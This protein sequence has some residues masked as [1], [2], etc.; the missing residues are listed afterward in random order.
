MH[1]TSLR[2]RRST[3]SV[4]QDVVYKLGQKL[5]TPTG[6]WLTNFYLDEQE[7]T[8]LSALPART[9]S[10]RRYRVGPLVLDL[11]ETG[12]MLAEAEF[13]SSEE[14]AAFRPPD[15]VGEEVTDQ[16]LAPEDSGAL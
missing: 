2:L 7:Y 11:L 16:L 9:L 6:R 12:L 14:M 13:A 4:S 15:W 3:C 8:V 10:K 1:G 5:T